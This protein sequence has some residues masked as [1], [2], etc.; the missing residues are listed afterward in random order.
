MPIELRSRTVP[1]P[2]EGVGADDVSTTTEG[3]TAKSPIGRKRRA[4][5]KSATS[6]EKY[7]ASRQAAAWLVHLYT[8][9]GLPLNLF[10]V[11]ALYYR[12]DFLR[13]CVFNFIAVFV[14]A[15]DGT[16]A[17]RVDVKKVT[18]NFDG[19]GLD[20]IVDYLTFA[21]LPALAIVAFQLVPSQSLQLALA[22]CSILASG[23]Q[24][25]QTV[26]KTEESFVGFPSYW[27]IVL[28]YMYLLRPRV[29][30]V[31]AVYVSCSI[32]SFVPMHFVY[33]SKTKKYQ[34]LTLS[35]A[36]I[37]GLMMLAPVLAPKWEHSE[38]LLK[39]SLFY[40]VY[41]IVISLMLHFGEKR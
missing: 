37:W 14:D 28:F 30:I 35:L 18:P 29:S 31:V 3:T 24:F 9:L 19:A 33:P 39:L 34:T 2:G 32:L 25:C 5:V 8:G 21:F 26:A 20:N 15:T 12:R 22:V 17:R 6:K 40:V 27:N 38:T 11:H 16:F 10:S 23:Y 1:K 4:S 7:T 36:V 41:Y 13:F